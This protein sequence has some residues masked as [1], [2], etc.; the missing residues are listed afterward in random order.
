MIL[1]GNL[2]RRETRVSIG[3]ESWES[4]ERETGW[5][6]RGWYKESEHCKLKLLGDA[7]L[8]VRKDAKQ[9][10]APQRR[11]VSRDISYSYFYFYFY[12]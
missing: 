1:N 11:K 12:I 9:A 7:K 2:Y 8:V 6:C 10:A 3:G 5:R 4:E